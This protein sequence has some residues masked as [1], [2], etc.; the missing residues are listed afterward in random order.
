MVGF[1]EGSG[2]AG[3]QSEC[4]RRSDAFLKIIFFCG[5]GASGW[6]VRMDVIGEVKFL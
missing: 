4:E 3:C 1:G 6:G 2:G 5:G